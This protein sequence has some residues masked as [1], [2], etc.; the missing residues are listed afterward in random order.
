MKASEGK[1]SHAFQPS[2]QS[3]EL[4]VKEI[5]QDRHL[6][7]SA[8]C[9][10]YLPSADVCQFTP[11]LVWD[12]PNTEIDIIAS[13]PSSNTL[14]Y[15]SCKRSSS[16]IDCKNLEDHVN[17]LEKEK[18]KFENLLTFLKLDCSTPLL[19]KFYHFVP[20]ISEESLSMIDLKTNTHIVTLT[21]MLEPFFAKVKSQSTEA[22][23]I[24]TER[25]KIQKPEEVQS[26]LRLWLLGL[27]VLTGIGYSVWNSDI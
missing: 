12:I 26:P 8:P 6:L 22:Q 4:W 21:D 18:E 20:S 3:F 17:Q 9:F 25:G 2:Q 13:H 16:K 1:I 5:A 27:I 23:S 24:I 15:G 7:C 10:P 11:K 19:K 14:I